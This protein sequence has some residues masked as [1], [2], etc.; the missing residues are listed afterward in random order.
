MDCDDTPLAAARPQPHPSGLDRDAPAPAGAW[1]PQNPGATSNLATS[2]TTYDS[3]GN[4]HTVDVYASV[5]D[6]LHA[7]ATYFSHRVIPYLIELLHHRG[8]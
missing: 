2:M 1:D 6:E 8:A 4:A 3:L 5:Q 7:R